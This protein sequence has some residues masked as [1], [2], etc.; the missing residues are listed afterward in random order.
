VKKTLIGILCLAGAGAFGQG[1]PY[2]RE[3]PVNT[4]TDGYQGHPCVASFVRGGFVICWE[5]EGQDGSGAGVFGQMFDERAE[6][7]NGE[8]RVN[9]YT[10]DDQGGPAATAL[11]AGGFVVCWGS[12]GQDRSVWGIYGQVFDAS[13]EKTRG[14]FRINTC[15]EYD[16]QHPCIA[17]LSDGGFV[18]CWESNGQDG[19][20]W[21]IYGQMFDASGRRI[22]GEFRINTHTENFQLAPSAAGLPGGGFIV[23]WES[24][25]QDG[26][27]IGIYGQIFD[28]SGARKN[29]E[30]RISSVMDDLRENP[31]VAALPG[32]GFF[33]CW[34]GALQPGMTRG[35]FGR[36]FDASGQEEAGEFRIDA[37][38]AG[39]SLD[40]GTV[41][42]PG[43][44]TV[45]CWQSVSQ[46][47]PNDGIYGQILQESG[48]RMNYEFAVTKPPDQDRNHSCIAALSGGGFVVCWDGWG[49]DVSYG[50]VSAKCFPF[51]PVSHALK[52]FD[53]VSPA[54]DTTLSALETTLIW[55]RPTDE[56][57][58]YPWELRYRVHFADNPDFF[59]A[60]VT[61]VEG[62]NALRLENLRPGT[63]CFWKV[64]AKNIAGDS[65]WSSS[66]SAFFVAHDATAVIESGNRGESAGFALH[67]NYPNPFN[68]ET[69]IRFDMPSSGFVVISIHDVNGR[70]VRSLLSESRNAGSHSVKWDGRDGTDRPVPSGIYICR[71]EARSVDGRGF[72]QSVK[73]GLV[74]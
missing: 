10:I 57:V 48:E 22:H 62:E 64:L 73:M 69:S 11:P 23:C 19:S 15:T 67:P 7:A 5:S 12:Y 59:D 63:T 43:G 21:G 47:I 33:V 32:G 24:E 29:D 72:A 20:G 17:A 40:A 68:P 71:M 13:G 42:L 58:C 2:G 74:R 27:G 9:T 66:T 8:F 45:V 51:P 18:V 55:D 26:I 14:E 38:E 52:P 56:A 65:L 28:G 16:Q 39:Y 49:V 3:F 53:P 31:V 30:F 6:K 50:G 46:G 34:D 4:Y 41:V 36:K 37:L 25:L 44:E 35:I 60:E 70:L 61:E 54:Y 1:V